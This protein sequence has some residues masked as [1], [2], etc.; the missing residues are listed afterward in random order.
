MTVPSA[1]RHPKIAIVFYSKHHGNTR[2]LL[3]TIAT[4]HEVTLIDATEP[5]DGD[6]ASYDLIGFA[7]GIYCFSFHRSVIKFA[8]QHLPEYKK[9][10]LMFTY[11][12]ERLKRHFCKRIFN[13]LFEKH[14]VIL[15]KFG[16]L[17]LCT[18]GPFK[19][20]GGTAQGHPDELD[21]CDAMDFYESL[22]VILSG[23]F[24]KGKIETSI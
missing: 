3:D 14:A 13:A 17:G 18:F 15:G 7:S 16:C 21:I 23:A 4:K 8:R 20:F 22:L 5:F 19:L 24:P 1:Q 12:G 11:G 2:L 9:V 6:L 10:F